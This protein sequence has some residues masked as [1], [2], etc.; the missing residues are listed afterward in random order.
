VTPLSHL[1]D[2]PVLG[3]SWGVT[4][5]TAP[6]EPSPISSTEIFL[7]QLGGCPHAPR[8]LEGNP[9]GWHNNCPTNPLAHYV[10]RLAVVDKGRGV[11]LPYLSQLSVN[12]T[13]YQ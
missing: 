2:R 10:D 7:S 12:P 5:P 3:E 8:K 11:A 9:R 13:N 4:V 6:T 1:Q